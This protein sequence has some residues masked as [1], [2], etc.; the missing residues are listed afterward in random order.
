M[1]ENILHFGAVRLRVQGTDNLQLNLY[2]LDN[3]AVTNLKAMP[4][5]PLPGIEP[6]RRCNFKAQRARFKISVSNIN[7]YFIINRVVVFVKPVA[8]AYPM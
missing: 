1:A 5:S 4:I 6:T 8:S 2:S 7:E 3:A